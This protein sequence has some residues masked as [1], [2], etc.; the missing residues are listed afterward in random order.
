[1]APVHELEA[2]LDEFPGDLED[3]LDLVRHGYCVLL[4]AKDLS[5]LLAVKMVV[6]LMY[7][8]GLCRGCRI[9]CVCVEVWQQSRP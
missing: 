4:T 6:E 5:E 1:M 7:V 3:F 8:Q 2:I 9:P